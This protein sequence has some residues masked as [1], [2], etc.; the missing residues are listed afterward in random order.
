MSK[1]K[2]KVFPYFIGFFGLVFTALL[3]VLLISIAGNP[4]VFLG[5]IFVIIALIFFIL[6]W[7]KKVQ[8]LHITI[9]APL[10]ISII[11]IGLL[12][13]AWNSRSVVIDSIRLE[14]YGDN[15]IGKI[16]ITAENLKNNLFFESLFTGIHIRNVGNLKGL[17]QVQSPDG[18]IF[19]YKIDQ[20]RNA[21]LFE[22]PDLGRLLG[23][24]PHTYYQKIEFNYFA[25]EGD[26]IFIVTPHIF[27]GAQLHS[28]DINLNKR[29]G[30]FEF[31]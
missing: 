1:L 12:V 19:K 18:K 20:L 23:Q 11:G 15:Y 25:R 22:G 30:I 4:V 26:Y 9:T 10:L 8:W 16:H 29:L 7:R 3:V 13:F 5:I 24:I 2:N 31:Y 14:K 21:H 28:V 6:V 27:S 17:I